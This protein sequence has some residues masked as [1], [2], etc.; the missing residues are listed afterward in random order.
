MFYLL[1]MYEC[2]YVCLIQPLGAKDQYSYGRE[3][4]RSLILFRFSSRVIRK[5][6]HKVGF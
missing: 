5:I 4:A 1:Y 2:V 6:M 3:T